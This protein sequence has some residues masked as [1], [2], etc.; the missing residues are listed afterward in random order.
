MYHGQDGDFD[1]SGSEY[2]PSHSSPVNATHADF[3]MLDIH[4]QD[5]PDDELRSDSEDEFR[6]DS[7]DELDNDQDNDPDIR[8]RDASGTPPSFFSP[9]LSHSFFS[10]PSSSRRSPKAKALFVFYLIVQSLSF[11]HCAP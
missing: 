7:E 3:E 2:A 5:P 9:T 8:M 1:D 6:S 11:S 10:Y 4:Q